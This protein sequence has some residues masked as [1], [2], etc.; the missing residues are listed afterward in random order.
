MSAD[1]SAD[2]GRLEEVE[3]I[4]LVVQS[5]AASAPNTGFASGVQDCGGDGTS[6]SAK[7]KVFAPSF[8][9]GATRKISW[10]SKPILLSS[11]LALS[12]G[13]SASEQA[14]PKAL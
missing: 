3:V 8:C 2:D 14:E 5:A 7:Q 12:S 9:G 1:G 11:R 6:T 13:R 10:S 4:A